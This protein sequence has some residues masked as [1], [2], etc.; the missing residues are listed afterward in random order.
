MKGGRAWHATRGA[1]LPVLWGWQLAIYCDRQPEGFWPM[2]PWLDYWETTPGAVKTLGL[3]VGPV[4]LRLVLERGRPGS[5][6]EWG[7][8]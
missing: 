4:R 3:D 7:L 8:Q 1:Q 6:A 5:R 2:R